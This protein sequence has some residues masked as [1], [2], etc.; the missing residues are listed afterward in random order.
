MRGEPGALRGIHAHHG[1]SH[2]NP[3]RPRATKNGR[4]PKRPTKF[5]PTTGTTEVPAK[6]LAIGGKGD[7]LSNA[8]NYADSQQG[9]KSVQNTCDGRGRRPYKKAQGEDPLHVE[10]VYQ[11][12]GGN[13]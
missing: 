8:E 4:H 9:H 11:P 7:R 12:T 1:T 3:A 6:N 13:L 2:S 5:P 10:A